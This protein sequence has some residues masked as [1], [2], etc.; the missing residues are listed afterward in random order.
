MKLGG[1]L[2]VL[3]DLDQ[4]EAHRNRRI[5]RVKVTID[6]KLGHQLKDCEVVGD[7]SEEGFEDLEEQDISFRFWLRASPLPRSQEE[8]K[9]K[10]STSS[11]CLESLFNISSGQSKCDARDKNKEGYV[12]VEQCRGTSTG[13]L[14]VEFPQTIEVPTGIKN[15]LEIE[16]VAESIGAVDISNTGK[17]KGGSVKGASVT[18]NKWI[19]RKNI[20]KVNL[21]QKQKLEIDIGNRQSV[22][23]MIVEDFVERDGS[24]EKQMSQVGGEAIPNSEP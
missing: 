21:S 8:Q 20:R 13:N 17:G 14:Q 1:I 18:Q 3:E 6:L 2:G 24:G 19:R 15:V 12:E 5:L 22:D 7:L 4:K 16:V 9:K 23:V 11:S 10:E